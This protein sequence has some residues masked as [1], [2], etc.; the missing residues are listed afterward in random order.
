MEV[1]GSSRGTENWAAGAELYLRLGLPLQGQGM[2]PMEGVEYGNLCRMLR[3]RLLIVTGWMGLDTNELWTV[4][5][6]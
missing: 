6:G 2:R 1:A 4:D 5:T 3:S